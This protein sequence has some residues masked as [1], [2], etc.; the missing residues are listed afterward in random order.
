MDDFKKTIEEELVHFNQLLES[1][2]SSKNNFLDTILKY[3]TVQKGKQLRP[4]FTLLCAKMGGEIN[5]QTY[6]AAVTI[7]VLHISS[8][9]H[10]D[11]IDN[12][13]E[14]RNSLSVNALWKN[15]AALKSGNFLFFQ[16]INELLLNEDFTILN[17]VSDCVQKIIQG[18]LLQLKKSKKR[19]MDYTT[20][21]EII[22]G[23]TAILLGT[24]CAVG[25]QS[26]FKN[27]DYT[28]QL[29]EFGEKL[30][31]AFQIKDDLFDYLNVN[32]GK[33]EN[34]DIIEGKMTLPVLYSLNQCNQRERKKYLNLL[35]LSNKKDSQIEELKKMVIQNG[36]IAYSNE[37]MAKY[38]NEALTILHAFPEN[39]TRNALEKIARYVAERKK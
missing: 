35:K 22:N 1:Y 11:I 10:D 28:K 13:D 27:K 2:L 6:R 9:L 34:N 21:F 3:I 12:A 5:Q 37:F 20:Y 36:G 14:R 38:I 25:A 30:G 19:N 17:I 7:E 39:E 31:M 33:S 26:T 8:L 18:E 29:F 32:T 15:K 23:K 16:S 24:A 4:I